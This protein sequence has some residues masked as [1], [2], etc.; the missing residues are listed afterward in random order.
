MSMSPEPIFDVPE[1]T[2]KVAKSAFPKGNRYI[3]MRD[4]LGTIY[5]DE[6]FADLYPCVGQPKQ[7]NG[8]IPPI[9][10][11]PSVTSTA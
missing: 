10:W 1:L 3:K 8:P 9:S 6:Q 4:E 7:S 2:A 11:R 5:S